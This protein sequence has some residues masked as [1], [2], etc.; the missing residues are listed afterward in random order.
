MP[1]DTEA[2]VAPPV[3]PPHGVQQIRALN[4]SAKTIGPRN[5]SGGPKGATMMTAPAA[6]NAIGQ[7]MVQPTNVT[8][9]QSLSPVLQRPEVVSPPLI[10]GGTGAPPPMSSGSARVN[11]ANATNRGSINGVTV[12]RPTAGPSGIGGPTQ[13]RYGING[14]TVQNR[15]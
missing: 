2:T 14:T 9:A 1:L 4:P 6:H 11:L 5:P 12:I 10:H 13:P 7:A 3:L 8:G 15:H